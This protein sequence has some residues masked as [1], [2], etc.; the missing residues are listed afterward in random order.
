[1]TWR[2]VGVILLCAVLS[3]ASFAAP[4][5]TSLSPTTGAV[6]ASV[7]ITGTNF[8]STQGTSTVKFNGTA[9]TSI[10]SW[11]ATSI[12]ATVPTGATT[13][14][15][16]VTVSGVASNGSSF[17]VVAAPSITSLSPTSGAVGAS[18]TIT[19]TNFGAT[20]G[21]ST[22]KFNGTAATSIT[23]WGATSIVAT[24]PTGATTGN[25]VVHASGVN[26]NGVA[27]TVLATPSIT[28]LSPTTG[29]VG[30]SVTITGTNFGSTQGT[31]TVK[32]NGTATTSITSWS[33]TSIV[34]TVPT[35]ATTGNV[36]VHASGV[37]SNGVAFTVLAT[38]SITSLSPTTGAVG[39]SVT[40]TGTNFG[41]TQGTSTVKFN[42]TATTS[43]TSWSATSIVATVPTGATTGN[44]VVTVSGVASNGSSFTVV[45]APS[46]T[47]LSP[48]SGAVGA[49]VTITG[50][51]FG[52]TQGTS[53]VAFN[54][55]TATSITSWGATS[56]V[57]TVPTGA[58]TGNVVVHAS[59][60]NSNGVAFTVLATPSITSLSPTTGAVGASVTITGTNFGATQGTSTVKFNGTAATSITSW[61]ATSIV[62][63][64]P[65]GATTGNVVVTVSGVA[66]NG[67]SFTV[68]AAPSITSLSPTSGAVGASVTITGTNFGATQG[69][70]TVAFNGTTATSITSWG[71]TSIVATVPTGATTGNVVVHASG[72]NSNGVA[73]T[74][75]AT[76]SITSLSP[77][78]GAVG[79]S[80]TITGT[81][82]GSTQGTSTVKFNGTATTSITS[83]SATSIVAT[84]PTGATTGNVVVTVSGVASNGS[85]FTVVAAPSITS[86]SPTSGAVGASVT[87]TGTNFGA[88]QGTSTVAFNGTTATS[89]TSWGAT[90]IVATVPTGATTGNVVV[91]ASGVNSN[92]VAFTVLA[93][94]S[95]TSLSP[96]TGAVG[97]SV[98]ITGTNFGATQG[99]STVKFNGTAATSITSWSAT[100][101]VATVPTGATTGNVV[102]TVS[103]VAS[104]GS[105]FT[106]VAAPSIT[107]LSPTSGAVGASVTI[108][109]TNFGATQGTS[110]VAFNGTTA[111]S[112]TSW[113]ATSIVATVPTGA[114]TGNVVVTVNG[115]ASNGSLFAVVAAP[116]IW[117]LAPTSAMV[118]GESVTITGTNFGATQGTSTVAFNG[119]TATSITS[120]SATSIVAVVPTGATT[121]NVVVYASGVNS[122]GVAFTVSSTYGN[123]YL[124]RQAL[125]LSH[126]NVPNTDQTNFPVLISG[127]YPYLA[128]VSN[129][130]LVQNSNGYDIVF[131]LDPE[132]ATR[133]DHEIDNYAAATGTAGFWVRI[134]TL[135]HT[136]DTVIY[137]FYGNPLVTVS[138]ENK[139][140]VWQSGYAAVW[141]FGGSTLS[142]AD[143]T[144][145][146]DNG[147]NQGAAL[148]TGQ[149]GGA[150]HFGGSGGSINFHNPSSLNATTG[151]MVSAWV[152]PDPVMLPVNGYTAYAYGGIFTKGS[153]ITGNGNYIMRYN[154]GNWVAAINDGSWTM[155]TSNSTLNAQTWTM[156]DMCWDGSNLFQY[157]NGVLD[158]ETPFNG[159][160]TPNTGPA[161]VGFDLIDEGGS[162][163]VTWIGGI[164]EVRV[165]TDGCRSSDWIA[166]EYAN[167][168]S[169]STFYT[170]VGQ[171]TPSG[172]PTIQLLS[173]FIGNVGT[174]VTILGYGFQ[175][176]QGVS[177]VTFNG[178]A[179]TPT[180]WNDAIIVAPVPTGATTGN[181]VVTV[182][183][184][185][186]NGSLFT[187]VVAQGIASL[188][189]TSGA[190]GASVTI[191]GINFG[192]T[193]GTSTVTFN[194]TAATITSWNATSIVAVVPT[195][196]TTGNVVVTV[197]G[198]VS[199]G[200]S[201]TV[202]PTPSI[203]S[204]SPNSGAVGASVTIAGIGFGATQG[205]S[206]LQFN[207][208]TATITSWSA[209]SIVATVSAAATTGN[210]VVN[211]SGVTSN[212]ISFTVV[213][214]PSIT[215]L[216]PISGAAGAS[217]T[218]TGT[219]F[220]S[221]QRTGLVTFNGTTATAITSWSATSIVAV[222]PTG[223]TTGNV[224]VYASGVNSNGVA[225]TVLPT[226]SITSL[227]PTS[228]AVSASVTITGTNF[229]STPGTN[230]VTFNGT[231][232]TSITSWSATSIVA[233]V[234]TGATTGNVVVTVN[235]V[236]SNGS[237][238][239]VV[240]A[241]NITS[242]SPTSGAVGALVTITGTNFG[243]TQGT[244]V[245]NT[246]AATSITSWSA[247]SIVAVVPTGATT[248]NVVVT[249]SGVASNGSSFTVS[250]TQS[251]GYPNGY[252]YRRTVVL[253][254]SNVPNTDQTDF[255]V[256][257]S[258]VYSY[259]A[260]ISNGGLVQSANGYDIIFSLD[261]E[262]A[263]KLDHEIDS[264]DSVTGT[265]SF[266]IR[267]PTLSHST[268]T[269]MYLFYGNP[270]V[271]VS[272]ENK[273]GVWKNNYLSVYHL[274]NGTTVG[275]ADSGSVGYTLAV[276]G[277]A[278]AGSGKIGGGVAFTGDPSIYLYND[279][280]PAYPSGASP[281]TL[282]TWV[283]LSV[284]SYGEI[285]GYG[286]DSGTTSRDALLW[287]GSGDVLMDFGS[288]SANDPWQTMSV[289]GYMPFD[290]NWHHLVSVYGGGALS[291][292][293]DQLYLDG[294][295]LLTTIYGGVPAITTAEFKIGGVPTCTDCSAV[296][297]SVD[298]VRVSSGVRSADWVAT[299]Y[300]NQSSPSTFYTVEGQAT[301]SGA[302]TIQ[303]LSP[304]AAAI[305]TPVTIEG[306][307]FQ[308]TQGSS[309]V[310]FNGVTA[311][312]TSWNDASIVVPVPNGATTGNVVV[313]VNG[314][315]SN[316]LSFTV[317]PTTI[318]LLSPASGTIG[319]VI[320]IQ[321]YG[322]QAVQGASTVTFNGVAATPTSWND[323][324]IVV[325]VPAGATTGNVVVTVGGVASN[326]LEFTVYAG[327]TS[328][329][330]FRQTIVLDHANVHNTDQ[331]DFPVLISGVY[332]Y[333]AN[334][335]SGGSVNSPNGYDIIFSSDQEGASKL[336][337]EI[338]SYDPLT[339]TVSFWVRIPTLSHTV[340]TV[341]Y[342]FYG[343]PNITVSQE[344]KAG[345]WK[346]NY[347]S[348]YHLG[349]G[350][351]VGLADS[352]SAGYALAVAGPVAAGP[353]KIGGGIAFNGNPSTYLYND[354]LP[355]YP[356]GSSPV[357]LET[358]VQLASS[359]GGEEI[360]AYGTNSA[361]GSRAGFDWDGSNVLLEFEN[362]SVSGPMPFDSNWHH[363]VGVYGGG[364]L[365]PT[366]DQ[367]YLDGAP[368]STT[369][370]AGTPAITTTE[371]KIGG[372]PTV[373]SCCALTGSVDEV[374]VS[375]GV[376][377]ADWVATEYANQSSPS[378]FYTVGGQEAPGSAPTIQL[379]SPSAGAIGDVITI[380]G[381]GFQP[382]Q[383]GST[384]TFNGVT[385]T[386]TS[387]NDANI[388]VPVPTGATTGNVKVTVG[389]VASNAVAFS[390]YTGYSSGYRYRQAIVLNHTKVPN[391]DQ[392]DFPV[393]ISGVY[394]NLANVN[395]GGY[396]QNPNGY[397]IIFSVDPEGA[398]RLDHEIDNYDPVTGTASFWVR[399][400]TL[401]HTAD[402]VIYVLYGNPDVAWSQENKAGVWR[403]NY[404]SVYHL[405]NGTTVGLADSGSA[406]YT[407][408]GSAAAVS[409]KIG[410]GAAF[411]GT[412]ETYLLHD[413][414]TAYPSGLSPVTLET[415]LQMAP[416]FY[417]GKIL[418]Y[419][420][421]YGDGYFGLSGG[422]GNL[423]FGWVDPSIPSASYINGT[424]PSDSNWH[425][426]VGV[427]GGGLISTTADQL[428]VDGAPI[429]T[430]AYGSYPALTTAEFKIG[431]VPTET[432]NCTYCYLTGS[433]DEV[434]VSSG[435]RSAD[436]VATEYA[437]QSSP[438]TFYGV[439]GQATASSAPT[440][441][442][443]SPSAGGIGTVIT[444]QGGGFQPTQGGSTVTFNGVTATP[445][446]WNDASIVV[447]VPAGATTGNVVVTVGGIAS[448]GARF[449]VMSVP[450]IT[451]LNP[452]VGA[453]GTPVT[454]TGTNF[455]S[456]QG[457]S[458]VTF[459]GWTATPTSW[460]A[461]S[462]VVPVPTGA[463]T[464]NVV[465]MVSGVGAAASNGSW[466]TVLP[467][468]T[469]NA[470]ASSG[471]PVSYTVTSGPATVNGNIL[472]ITGVGSVTVQA[473]QVGNAQYTTAPPTSQT[474][475]VNQASQTITFTQNAPSF[476]P[477][478]SSFT[479][480]ATA[481]SGLPVSFSSS[482]VCTNVGANFTMTSSTGTCTVTASQA[483]NVN[484]LAA[485]NVTQTTTAS[486]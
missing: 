18:V 475:T 17:T 42:G 330:E 154:G 72:V 285:F 402:T 130:G 177:T 178:V 182:G 449:A 444:I 221:T 270:S 374:R 88:T 93:T 136:V 260:T 258:G 168:S 137:V 172:A 191:T 259:L 305:A 40:I 467:T 361:N 373:T 462:I 207:G 53:T 166:T 253:A 362:M 408:T 289:E 482:G 406:G 242:L 99:T 432:L 359:T 473:N 366:T 269:I 104:N 457:A 117:S 248:G 319:E 325:P 158:T 26:S 54:G 173:P 193:Q 39:A 351:T 388:V 79:A 225:F 411:N 7:T 218:I 308:P 376:R 222:V 95:I 200:V 73:F 198:V 229:G 254:H 483:G 111:T 20:Q 78:T 350:T 426:L 244:V 397:D 184:V 161:G 409:G 333:L 228:G 96:T 159:T 372:I 323:V 2:L 286:D 486:N 29:A 57:A 223:A 145:N 34:A 356:S 454:I 401:S 458:T 43:I 382:T 115:V 134:P 405:G 183:G 127:V 149:I 442:F 15:V 51:N 448:N 287:D 153:Y 299:E 236:A 211:A 250:G 288:G 151:L 175:T 174:V 367:L 219:N 31:S 205:T 326:G 370:V 349:N 44:V 422:P 122:N 371:F 455:G 21:T 379:L 309:T 437:N 247:T 90:S 470:A 240:A 336:D 102:V 468:V 428:Y 421:N 313:N 427:Y 360:L 32:F 262:G 249:V 12:V 298:E 400:P 389:G 277:S 152:N 393:L 463:T 311:T 132:G 329:Y 206:T 239:A 216:S 252:Q 460:T 212:G 478:N 141:H 37:N 346:N 425:H 84:V 324:S 233:V 9:A 280:L 119:T 263:S 268:D 139:P 68:V 290:N 66:S 345:V 70:S 317:L 461:T 385:A 167:Q 331:T 354:S 165:R 97:A 41:S 75:L 245:F 142:M 363:L 423:L 190:V 3:G 89:I 46:I 343:N 60:V 38:P 116:S 403:N 407:L 197:S 364:A 480:A 264:Y 383:G 284:S 433:V 87:I 133:L 13:G 56:I 128:N 92:G 36:V 123:G 267:I 387:W 208:T 160:L 320:T 108:T 81:N 189:P 476:A 474:F 14:N 143:S 35:G 65:T 481:S 439:E 226:P 85:S 86:L 391:T 61:S 124:Y 261:P 414:V 91:H 477:N 169:P 144:S 112:I 25:V 48:T 318:Q 412:P 276:A 340:D 256:L 131:S 181:V 74:V 283:Q 390:V 424:M 230:T 126:A 353:G 337:H 5:I 417:S 398:S 302:P 452:I 479:V 148:T 274:G 282:E 368:L 232:A 10:T 469:L 464:G 440:I 381:Y 365:S 338:D 246:T 120:W 295:P 118:V 415:W 94:P 27:F 171:A 162:Q 347:L 146:G 413:S 224:V 438:S 109:G 113:G 135:S 101:I 110:T 392:T 59:G 441:Q 147:T 271:T 199:N 121:G 291:T 203:T 231:T 217:V 23:S 327:Y 76:P 443:L 465:V 294:A 4:S 357:T 215:N 257:V 188:S 125:V 451:N 447:P 202:L 281:V 227:S 348:V 306:Y 352:G 377:S 209:G 30:A 28:S 156:L 220:G 52:A 296:T 315:N 150:A 105:S 472:T 369:V 64:V 241:P 321:G 55:T 304:A 251:N 179:A 399:I 83:W 355:A 204:L 266:W 314:V 11:G 129:G 453:V 237:S 187:V 234:P 419:G 334:V 16:V 394:S 180:S 396:V 310:T 163:G 170:V 24:V 273:A 275:L 8:G 80:V 19:G 434:R 301:V 378:T 344:N 58:T 22:V 292:T 459:N 255:P 47:S 265:A 196:A 341:I 138:Q 164:D 155:G 185:A 485:T 375:S 484:Y 69:T 332:S 176:A 446:N 45:A 436:W 418:A 420:D 186:S 312:P 416:S 213:P 210:V 322:F 316:G 293:T 297:G 456:T 82:F 279:L 1:M 395:N 33:A 466:F 63:T 50:T 107:S 195:G 435:V 100:S 342:L 201:F 384:V 272:Q 103:G 328:G 98:T 194:G 106:V 71:A 307:G 6:G 67:S 430:S 358:W 238:F 114:T 243:S 429:S 214:A 235:G 49:S 445:V 62:A 431:G 157:T 300:A 410:G 380:Q 471:L 404:L 335:G 140:G 303:F 386:P 278:T 192:S 77:T 450:N 339:G